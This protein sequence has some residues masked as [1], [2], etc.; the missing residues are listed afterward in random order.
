MSRFGPSGSSNNAKRV[1][2]HTIDVTP[3]TI[4]EVFFEIFIYL[5][6]TEGVPRRLLVGGV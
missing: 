2:E 4:N 3:R 6:I 5:N 1:L